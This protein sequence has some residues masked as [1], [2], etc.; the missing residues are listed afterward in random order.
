[1]DEDIGQGVL[2]WFPG[3]HIKYRMLFCSVQFALY[4]EGGRVVVLHKLGPG[5]LLHKLPL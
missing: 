1:M 4:L 5:G 2:L 3:L